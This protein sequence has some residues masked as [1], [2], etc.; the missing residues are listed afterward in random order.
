[1]SATTPRVVLVSRP[2]D[3]QQLVGRHGTENQVRF[4]LNTRGQSL[5]E[6]KA[7]H[8]AHFAAFNHLRRAIPTDWRRAE[9]SREDLARFLFEP[10]DVVV[11]VGQDGLVA[12]TAKYL[13]GQYVLGVNPEP[14]RNPG[15]LVPH[16][17]AAAAELLGPTA[18]R[19]VPVQPRAMV[20]VDLDGLETLYAVNELFIGQRTHQS[21]RY[22][23]ALGGEEERQSSSGLIVATGTGA[24]G[25]AASI[26]R[27]RVDDIVLPTPEEPCVAFLVRE[28]WPSIA[29]GTSITG[30]RLEGGAVLTVTS[31]M[32]DGG[33]IFGDGIEAD[34]LSFSW[35]RVATLTVAERRL[36]LV[37]G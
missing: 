36:M 30:G 19:E 25:W 13:D 2:T 27:E 20:Q 21:A 14:E 9:V 18:T 32:D 26:C 1:M 15:I 7:R 10:E 31:E 35:G 4:F 6:V 37:T 22:R 24:T 11:V 12:N 23:I 17:P 29:T 3:Y 5:D 8:D 28:A 16:H 33:V 34:A